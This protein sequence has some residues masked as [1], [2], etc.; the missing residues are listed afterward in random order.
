M[1]EV[2]DFGT[3]AEVE[4]DVPVSGLPINERIKARIAARKRKLWPSEH[5]EEPGWKLVYRLPTDREQLSPIYARAEKYEKAK[6]PFHMDATVLATF[7]V[8]IWELG[9]RWESDG[10]PLTFR[11]REVMEL[12]GAANPSEA[13]RALYGSDGFVS[14]V[15]EQLLDKA[16]YGS[17]ANVDADDEDPSSAG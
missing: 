13:V 15:A 14:T 9:E 6:L 7:S 16:G 11:D 3:G 2:V 10:V 12:L 4:E 8:E 1:S 5:P 17:K